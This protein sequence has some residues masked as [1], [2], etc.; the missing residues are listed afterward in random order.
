MTRPAESTRK[1]RFGLYE[2]D[3]SEQ[4]LYKQGRKVRLQDQPF[5]LL[6]C[7]V[8]RPRE[9]ITRQELSELLWPDGTFADFDRGLNT[10]INKL[11]IALGDAA[12]NPRF[13]ETVPR[14]GYRFVAPLEVVDLEPPAK[15][16]EE[17]VEELE[18]GTN[19]ELL[20]ENSALPKTPIVADPVVRLPEPLSQQGKLHRLITPIVVFL[21]FAAFLGVGTYFVYA[22][23][24][25]NS[26]AMR[27]PIELQNR[28]VML[29]VLPLEN[30]SV[31]SD[32]QYFSDGLT[33]E[34]TTRLG[35]LSP[36]ELGV[37][38]R[39]TMKQYKDTEIP[40]SLIGTELGVDYR[41]GTMTQLLK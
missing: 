18:A 31:D 27:D 8:Q 1:V 29:A 15:V 30:L 12:E 20:L 19:E 38:A 40:I 23:F 33:Q 34:L 4:Q 2:L 3:Y 41:V 14:R 17:I 32:Q 7:F 28:K 26:E 35:S 5:R 37:I 16:A 24:F 36:D 6:C 13:L 22:S 39:T 10:A 9:L 21:L 25:S 11:R